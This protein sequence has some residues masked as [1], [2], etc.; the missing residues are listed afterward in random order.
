MGVDFARIV[1]ARSGDGQLEKYL[2]WDEDR[3]YPDARYASAVETAWWLREFE[4]HD[5]SQTGKY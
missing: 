5:R 1:I 3:A 4:L 2:V